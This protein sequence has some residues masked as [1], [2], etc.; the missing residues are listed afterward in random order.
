MIKYVLI[1]FFT[2]RVSK[3]STVKMSTN[4]FEFCTIY[5]QQVKE[6]RKQMFLVRFVRRIE[7]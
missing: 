6:K 4:V 7:H 2:L 1:Y 3:H 5:G